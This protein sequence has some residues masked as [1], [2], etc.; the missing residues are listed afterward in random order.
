MVAANRFDR[1]IEHILLIH[2]FEERIE[3]GS[4]DFPLVVA[5]WDDYG[6]DLN[7]IKSYVDED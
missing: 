1:T 6:I 3:Y 5:Y 7:T 2:D 4:K